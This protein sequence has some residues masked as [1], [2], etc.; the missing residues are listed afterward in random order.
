MAEALPRAAAR[1]SVGAPGRALGRAAVAVCVVVTPWVAWS[2]RDVIGFRFAHPWALV[3]PVAA[4]ALVLY[5]RLARGAA[6]VPVLLHARAAEMA[7]LRPGWAV[8]WR[9]LPMALRVVAVV[10]IGLALARPQSRQVANDIEVEGIDIVIALDVSGSM[11]ETDL[12]PNRLDAAKLVIERFVARRPSDRIG[13]V[14]FARDAYTHVPLTLDH[15]TY[16]RM[17]RELTVGV[18]DGKGTAIGNGIGVALN[19]LRRSDARSKVVIL[20]TDG[21][22]NSGNIAPLEAARMAKTLGVKVYT[23]LAGANEGAAPDPGGDDPGPRQRYAVNPKLLDEIATTTGGTSYLATDTRALAQRFQAILEDLETSRIHDRGVLFSE[24]F[25]R[26]LAPAA[27]LLLLER[28]L[29]LTRLR[30]VP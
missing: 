3:L 12:T 18:V 29:Q 10:L 11:E 9:E 5:A 4:V 19:R 28:L 6:R 13:L 16:L 20:L 7:R 14:L 22:N 21:D 17:L 27:L 1:G 15:G 26:F 24:L 30:R 2:L 8:R 23:I 25:P